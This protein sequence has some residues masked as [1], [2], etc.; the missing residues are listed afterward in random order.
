MSRID[1]LK[2]Q[3]AELDE[4]IKAAI[5]SGDYD[6]LIAA[7]NAIPEADE[8]LFFA[9]TEAIRQ[10]IRE[11]EDERQTAIEVRQDLQAESVEVSNRVLQA[12]SELFDR[13][14][15]FGLLQNKLFLLDNTVESR[16]T[17]LIEAQK[18][19]DLHVKSRLT[20]S[21]ATADNREQFDILEQNYICD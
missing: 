17:A 12:R 10:T 1:E 7:R 21:G 19:L 5:I 9:Q 13:E 20:G 14:N 15:E 18:R 11:M 6:S 8:R 16:R 4:R 3:R 2:T